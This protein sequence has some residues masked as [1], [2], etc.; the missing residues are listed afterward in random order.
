MFVK[1]FKFFFSTISFMLIIFLPFAVTV[2]C[3]LLDDKLFCNFEYFVNKGLLDKEIFVRL[4]GK[5]EEIQ[6]IDLAKILLVI[7]NN[8]N[9][10]NYKLNEQ[11]EEI[12]SKLLDEFKVE[13]LMLK[14]DDLY[15][16]QEN[17]IINCKYRLISEIFYGV[18]VPGE[19]E[20]LYGKMPSPSM[21]G[22]NHRVDISLKW[23]TYKDFTSVHINL[24]H[25]GW[26]GGGIYS[27]VGSTSGPLFFDET[28]LKISISELI[29]TKL[30]IGRIRFS[31]GNLGI[32]A[33]NISE[34]LS[35]LDGIEIN[36]NIN[37]KFGVIEIKNIAGR[38][39]SDF[40]PNTLIVAG[41]DNYLVS[42]VSLL[43]DDKVY[44]VNFLWSGISKEKGY[45]IDFL[46][47]KLGL[48]SEC[49]FYY[50]GDEVT[51]IDSA[52]TKAFI[53][54]ILIP[55]KL[56]D[57]TFKYGD[58]KKNFI[59]YYSS[60]YSAIGTSPV[61]FFDSGTRGIEMI[62][63]KKLKN[64][65]E[66]NFDITSFDVPEKKNIY[67]IIFC[68]NLLSNVQIQLEC[69]AFCK[70]KYSFEYSICRGFIT[71]KF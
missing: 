18:E 24:F 48:L 49:V 27:S 8:I 20:K 67:R 10:K 45:S 16:K 14:I 33:S 41:Q 43:G 9:S 2:N 29:N 4:Q 25:V 28:Y 7:I 36:N 63:S 66:I 1:L 56:F 22:L 58:I 69:T 54:Q 35:P 62:F 17:M 37:T 5:I 23:K 3:I 70:Y 44:G 11:D 71:A 19:D 21:I 42:R 61:D 55:M 15:K 34:I 47:K 6:R 50:P 59:S 53:F 57:L 51:F 30:K 65:F 68:F 32:L 26:W 38:I 31:C 12:L 39:T 64:N 40:Y 13:L 46:I 60:L 52:W